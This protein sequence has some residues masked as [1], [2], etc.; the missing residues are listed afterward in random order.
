MGSFVFFMLFTSVVSNAP[1]WESTV[2]AEHPTTSYIRSLLLTSSSVA[3]IIRALPSPPITAESS[4]KPSFTWP[5][6]STRLNVGA[7]SFSLIILTISWVCPSPSLL[8]PRMWSLHSLSSSASKGFWKQGIEN[9]TKFTPILKDGK[10]NLW[11]EKCGKK[12]RIILLIVLSNRVELSLLFH[13][14][15][16]Q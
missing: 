6:C 9:E 1:V 3:W 7:L 2:N 15:L 16:L 14:S 8:I 4:G 11:A 13:P 5:T 12:T 10:Y